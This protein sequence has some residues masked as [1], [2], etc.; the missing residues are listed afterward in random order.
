MIPLLDGIP[1][2][3]AFVPL[4]SYLVLLGMIH[5]RRR[6]L[7]LSRGWDWTMLGAAAAGLV[8]VGPLALV[9]PMTGSTPW[10]AILLLMLFALGV[11]AATLVS[12]PR[13]VIYNIT[14]DQ[15]RPL[16]ADV[17]SS[18]DPSAR[19]AGSTAALPARRFEVRIEPH[20]PTRAVS[21]VAGGERPGTDAWG[22]FCGRLRRGLRGVRVQRSSWGAAFLA[23]GI[24]I[25]SLS[26]WF[27]VS[28]RWPPGI[29]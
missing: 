4:G 22:E 23:I 12:R 18:L 5:L 19:W 26:G 24:V 29:S 16:M 20:G 28:S 15:L 27:A 3:A 25:L 9:Q 1:L 11:A 13:L 14:V 21:I 10:S 6:P 2:W 17:V 7:M 8:I